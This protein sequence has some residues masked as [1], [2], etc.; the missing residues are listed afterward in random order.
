MRLAVSQPPCQQCVKASSI[1]RRRANVE[2]LEC[3]FGIFCC[4]SGSNSNSNSSSGSS[5][6]YT[7]QF[8]CSM[9][10]RELQAASSC[11]PLLPGICKRC[12]LPAPL[13][14]LP[15][16]PARVASAG[17]STIIIDFELCLTRNVDSD[18]D[19]KRRRRRRHC[20][21]TF[22]GNFF[23]SCCCCDCIEIYL[24][25]RSNI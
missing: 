25:Q 20:A 21:F 24:L 10:S 7:L 8:S 16:L 17:N 2:E 14:P 4:S 12:T 19:C 9:C 23:G 22:P 15:P 3:V 5:S 11:Q 13:L 6:S 1:E 18:S